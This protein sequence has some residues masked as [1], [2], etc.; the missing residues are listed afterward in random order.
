VIV[1]VPLEAAVKV[2]LLA[3]EER[4]QLVAVPPERA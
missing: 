3:D 4:L 2:A 1:Q